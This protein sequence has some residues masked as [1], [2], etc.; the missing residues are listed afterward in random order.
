[1]LTTYS[2]PP[3]DVAIH[4]A[5]LIGDNAELLKIQ[6]RIARALSGRPERDCCVLCSEAIASAP[7][8]SHRQVPYR[9][10]QTC[11]HLQC[12]LLAPAGY[13]YEEQ[14]FS[15]I[16]RPLDQAAF[17][18]R[19]ARIH[20]PKLQWALQAGLAA[21]L[22]DLGRR[23]WI[24]LGSGA[25]NFIDAL[26]KAGV[27]QALGLEAE[28]RL[29]EQAVLRLGAP[30]VKAFEGSLAEAMATHPADV[31]AAWF[32]L[33][34]CFDLPA[35]LAALRQRPSGT[36]FVFSVPTLGLASLLEFAFPGHY[37]RSLDS[38]LHLQLFTDRSIRY[39]MDMA[40][41]DI[42][43][44]WIFGQDAD[45]L[46]R[47]VTVQMAQLDPFAALRT[48]VGRLLAA[49]PAIQEAVDRSRLADSRHVM[50]VRR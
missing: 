25:G 22:G 19:T 9:V 42:A 8:F 20:T 2:K 41:Y 7:R 24:E 43:A 16:Y 11:G 31:Y 34:H 10:C 32:V 4:T 13:P 45:D 38:V 15:S 26:R 44:E 33:E 47:A 27:D 28:P 37:A 5:R 3:T 21:G 23:H 6:T 46:Y 50:A 30:L 1:M 14:D 17:A 18:D 29:V 36:L 35:L 49:V 39:A 40:G 12:A 48:D